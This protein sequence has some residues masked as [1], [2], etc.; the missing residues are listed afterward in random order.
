[1]SIRRVLLLSAALL[2]LCGCFGSIEQLK[3][4]L[5]AER[6]SRLQAWRTERAGKNDQMQTLTGPLS[7]ENAI[8]TAI[9]NS[10][11]IQ[12]ALQE[13]EKAD[14]KVVEAYAQAA[15][16]V[17]LVA[18]YTRLDKAP[19][20]G[21]GFNGY[22]DNYSLAAAVTQPLYRGGAIGAGIR[23]AKIYTVL[24]DEQ[25]RGSFQN[26]IYAVRRA[27]Y[28][29]CLATELEMASAEA[30]K[31]A[32]RHL[33]DVRKQFLA[34]TVSAYDV[35][36]AEVELKNLIAQNVQN[37][38]SVQVSLTNLYNL[39][40]V[41]QESAVALT[42][43]L[44]Y[45]PFQDPKMEEA[46]DLAYLQQ[47]DILQSDLNILLQRE[48]LAVA[49][50]GYYPTLDGLLSPSLNKPDSHDITNN[51]WTSAWTAGLN[52]KYV[53][54][55]G[56]ATMARV[57]QAR[58]TLR[59]NEL[60]RTNAE[61]RILLLVRQAILNLQY[62]DRFVQSQQAN[63]QQAEEALRLA[64][65]GF[66]EG[67]RKE[68]EVADARRS[69]ISARANRAQAYYDHELARLLYEQATGTIEPPDA[70]QM[71]PP[72]PAAGRPAPAQAPH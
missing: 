45:H 9:G 49:K 39:M 22:K 48:A 28:D 19:T 44:G 18:N 33:E 61:Q 26:V 69:L 6:L 65:L 59:Q 34:G 23:A 21:P 12:I 43:T 25:L 57:R 36:S 14:A 56:F 37:Q 66:R 29:S 46:V 1:M 53:L 24:V 42:D 51:V 71:R 55:E 63:V 17:E 8:L 50:S 67:V 2:P 16:R 11:D 5:R 60:Q 72:E 68:V 40:G 7:L 15:P 47:T 70:E 10:R 54:F 41:S 4:D 30:V 27:Y 13:R 58:A 35:L 31:V 52:L 62:A 32:Q 64:E 38:N 3:R 20:M